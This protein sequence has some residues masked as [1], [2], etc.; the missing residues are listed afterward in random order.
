MIIKKMTATFGGLN[1]AVLEPARGLTVIHAPN[2]SGKSTWAGFLR[3]MLYGINTR[4]RDKEG[5]LAEKNRYAPWSGAPME[6]EIQLVWRG[7]EITLRRYAKKANPFGGFEAVYTASGDPVPGLTAENVGEQ[8]I[9]A[10]R[11]MYERSGFV[12]Q[13]S[14]A[15]IGGAELERRIAGLASTGE[16]ERGTLRKAILDSIENQNNKGDLK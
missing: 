14:T 15:V 10:G 12:G 13:G 2:E 6:G 8:L 11:E 3:A 7:E 9:G 4:E 1:K 5:Y 16:E